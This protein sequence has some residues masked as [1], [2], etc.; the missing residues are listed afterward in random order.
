MSNVTN[1]IEKL[2]EAREQELISVY[3]PSIDKP[4]NFYPL[5]VKQQKLLLR[6]SID[7]ASG[8][9]SILKEM[10]SII[11]ENASDKTVN[12]LTIDKYPVLLALRQQAI[13]N[14]I[15]INSKQ[16]NIDELPT[17]T[18]LE[19]KYISK[20]IDYKQFKVT[21]DLPTLLQDN[22]FLVKTISETAKLGEDKVKETLTTMYVYEIAKFIRTISFG[23]IIVEFDTISIAEKKQVVE[24]LPMKLNQK[25]LNFI[26]NVRELENK[27]ITFADNTII[28]INTLFLSTQ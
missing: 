24:S 5:N 11:L 4:V 28:P 22:N 12:F 21:L 6:H 1:F 2:T 27:F 14:E 13:G 20:T 9:I 18:K 17:P 8:M 3:I 15:T 25:I 26:S 16:Y 7:G 23:D 19:Q 10:N